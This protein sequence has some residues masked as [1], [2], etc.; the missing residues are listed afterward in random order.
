MNQTLI[1]AIIVVLLVIIATAWVFNNSSQSDQQPGSAEIVAN[2]PNLRKYQQRIEQYIKASLAKETVKHPKLH[3]M[4]E[5][6][7][8]GGKKIRSIILLSIL[9]STTDGVDTVNS[10]E[11]VKNISIT[12]AGVQAAL[13][14]EYLHAASLV[15][16]DIMDKDDYRRGK[17]S[18]HKVYG[19]GPAQM[20]ALFLIG[21]AGKLLREAARGTP[22]TAN[23]ENNENNENN[24][25]IENARNALTVFIYD[26]L[27]MNLRGLI[28]GQYIDISDE[29]SPVT[30]ADL[31]Q[32]KTGTLF[33]IPFVLGWTIGHG[34]VPDDTELQSIRDSSAYFGQMFQVADDFEDIEKDTKSGAQFNYAINYGKQ[35]AYNYFQSCMTKFND[36]S[37]RVNVHTLELREAVTYLSQK[38]NTHIII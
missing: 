26:N 9:E 21:L 1:A 11:N 22:I 33:E 28:E 14:V 37:S 36:I 15:L 13:A 19:I 27:F 10:A 35:E 7:V 34:K 12:S 38:V 23:S 24:E 31:I 18:V 20:C 29:S 3:A 6:A 2:L 4:C 8:S 32:K 30:G 17:V 5:H 25:N 16:D